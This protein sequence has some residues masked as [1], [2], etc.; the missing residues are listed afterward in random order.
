MTKVMALFMFCSEIIFVEIPVFRHILPKTIILE[1]KNP[2]KT[3]FRGIFNVSI[4][5]QEKHNHLHKHPCKFLWGLD[6]ETLLRILLT[7]QLWL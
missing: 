2:S 3:D 5:P 1:N 6:K 7:L 4:T